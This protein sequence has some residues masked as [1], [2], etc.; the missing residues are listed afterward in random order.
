MKRF[1]SSLKKDIRSSSLSS[2]T[3]SSTSTSTSLINNAFKS[4]NTSS[5]NKKLE[6]DKN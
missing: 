3:L 2:T 4:E 1:F 6:V 5:K